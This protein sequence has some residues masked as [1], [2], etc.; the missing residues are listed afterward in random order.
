MS[1][2]TLPWTELYRPTSLKEVVGNRDAIKGFNEWL[3]TWFRKMP[4]KRGALLIGPPGVGKTATTLAMA[5]DAGLEIVEFN[6]S[7][8]R[9]K[10]VIEDQVMQ[11]ATQETLGGEL[12]LILLDEVDGLSGTGD[13]GGIGAIL[14]VLSITLHPIVMTANDPDNPKIKDLFKVSR[15]F[16]FSTI[17][18]KDMLNVLRRIIESQQ[19]HVDDVVL[20][21]IVENA[22]GDLR[23]AISDL[24]AHIKGGMTSVVPE[25][26]SRD[27]RRG[28]ENAI[29]RLLMANNARTAKMVI[30]EVDIDHEKLLLWLEENIH[31]HLELPRELEDAY[32]A[33]SNADFLIGK[34]S[35]N[36]DWRLLSYVYDFLSAGIATSRKTTSFK[37]VRYTEP[38]WP[39]LVW[40]GN[41]RRTK[42]MSLI[43]RLAMTTGVSKKRIQ[44][45]HLKLIDVL[46]KRTPKIRV[47]ISEWLGVKKAIIDGRG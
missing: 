38:T 27:V 8:K 42:R 36:Q 9:N 41:R 34:I 45:T 26:A 6:A 28:I 43:K 37:K 44:R 14:K 18:E 19:V 1:E 10:A 7:D 24:E 11:A 17:Q 20:E 40:Q 31:L 22:R 32:D 30:S 23:A 25:F 21:Y 16:R 33:L 46:I 5:K 13:R 3:N 39:L 35:I 2:S 15:V 29:R 47:Q 12:R 4:E